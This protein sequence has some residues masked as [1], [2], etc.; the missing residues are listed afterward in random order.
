MLCASFS[1]AIAF[2]PRWVLQSCYIIGNLKYFEFKFLALSLLGKF[3]RVSRT[4]QQ[5]EARVEGSMTRNTMCN[6]IVSFRPARH[7]RPSAS[8]PA[9][10][11]HAT[12]ITDAFQSAPHSY[13][14]SRLFS[15]FIFPRNYLF[16]NFLVCQFIGMQVFGSMKK[17]PELARACLL[18]LAKVSPEGRHEP[19]HPPFNDFLQNLLKNMSI[20]LR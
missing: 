14:Y 20:R 12:A 17:P 6:R 13:F 11:L 9:D 3:W 5:V 8:S 15:L 16:F 4:R 7:P 19:A 18:V 2:W 1:R 10:A